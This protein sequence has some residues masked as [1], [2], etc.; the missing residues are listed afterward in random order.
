M[1]VSCGRWFIQFDRGEHKTFIIDFH[2]SWWEWGYVA[3]FY[4]GPQKAFS[5][6]PIDFYWNW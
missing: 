6:G 2:W 1:K 5:V 4:D 3:D